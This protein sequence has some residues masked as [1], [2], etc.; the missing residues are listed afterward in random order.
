[1]KLL[2]NQLI[3]GHKPE[4]SSLMTMAK[5]GIT[6][7]VTILMESEG[8]RKIK[9]M[10]Q[11]QGLNWHWFSFNKINHPD[12]LQNIDET[13]FLHQAHTLKSHIQKSRYRT[14]Y[15]HGDEG[16]CRTGMMVY[17]VYQ[18]LGHSRDEARAAI[19]HIRPKTY[20]E[21]GAPC[22]D[23]VDEMLAN[24]SDKVVYMANFKKAS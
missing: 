11:S 5:D 3:I 24:C 18:L 22:L 2:N 4:L 6:D 23:R 12:Q 1:M 16:I 20:Q 13:L 19:L 21:M 17:A 14:Y 8:A 9:T 10:A 15:I 7:V